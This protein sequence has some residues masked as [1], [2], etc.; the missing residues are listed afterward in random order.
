MISVASTLLRELDAAPEVAQ[1]QFRDR[2]AQLATL[3]LE[4]T[5]NYLEEI[6]TRVDRDLERAVTVMFA[7]H[8]PHHKKAPAPPTAIERPPAPDFSYHGSPWLTGTS[9]GA[10]PPAPA[11][12]QP[13]PR[14]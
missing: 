4:S 11:A 12:P 6:L 1:R 8:S 7:P 5:E 2:L 3:F 10:A 14:A 13:S 9:M